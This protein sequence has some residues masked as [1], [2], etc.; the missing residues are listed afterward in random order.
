[1]C[2]SI[3]SLV[4]PEKPAQTIY[5]G[6][7]EPAYSLPLTRPSTSSALGYN[8]VAFD[9]GLSVEVKK[10][11]GFRKTAKGAGLTVWPLYCVRGNGDVVVAY[12]DL[13]ERWECF[14]CKEDLNS[15]DKYVC[16]KIS[17]SC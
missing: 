4:D 7:S 13:S 6:D 17:L 3:Y 2:Y 16:S 5:L 15:N 11:S 10:K 8:V 1:M 12:S 14:N 9:F